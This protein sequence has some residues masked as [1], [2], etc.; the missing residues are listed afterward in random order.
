[1]Q[2]KILSVYGIEGFYYIKVGCCDVKFA[3]QYQQCKVFDQ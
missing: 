2:I 1:M 3:M